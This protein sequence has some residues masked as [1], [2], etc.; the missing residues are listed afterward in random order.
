MAR[1]I[2]LRGG[3]PR[4]GTQPWDGYPAA[5]RRLLRAIDDAGAR[6][7]VVLSGDAHRCVVSDLKVDFTRPRSPVVAT[8]LCGPS[9]TSPGGPARQTAAL[10]LANPH[11]H[12]ADAK[13]RGYVLLELAPEV[14]RA[15][16]R[17]LAD[18]AD[19][20]TAVFTLAGFEI[21]AGKPGVVG[22][23]VIR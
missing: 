8:E 23:P 5:R 2:Q 6:S 16:L 9:L 3:E 11:I 18:V 14:C 4:F 10:K 20:D 1:A 15:Q 12:F 22:S 19:P 13:H 7:A 17:M 21:R